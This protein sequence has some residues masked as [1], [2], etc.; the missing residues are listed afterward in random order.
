MFLESF[1][2]LSFDRTYIL[3]FAGFAACNQVDYIAA[4]TFYPDFRRI[5]VTS[6]TAGDVSTHFYTRLLQL[7]L[8]P[9]WNFLFVL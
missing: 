6:L 3:D 4:L 7:V 5:S 9:G 8:V 2:E 1:H